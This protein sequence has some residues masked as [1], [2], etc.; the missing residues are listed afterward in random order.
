MVPFLASLLALVSF[1]WRRGKA[2]VCVA[3]IH[4]AQEK[5]GK[6][7]NCKLASFFTLQ[8]DLFKWNIRNHKNCSAYR[9]VL[10]IYCVI[11][12]GK[13]IRTLG[14]VP[15]VIHI[16]PITWVPL[17]DILLCMLNSHKSAQSQE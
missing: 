16:I 13:P 10:F 17:N 12:S 3:A 7:V 8:R 4:A 2:A 5:C 15:E 1:L 9:K 6:P 11:V 14:S